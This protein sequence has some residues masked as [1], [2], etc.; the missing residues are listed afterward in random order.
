LTVRTDAFL[1]KEFQVYDQ[2]GRLLKTGILSQSITSIDITTL[3]S[4]IYFLKSGLEVA[5]FIKE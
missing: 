4:G 5:S 2:Q 1:G 3:K